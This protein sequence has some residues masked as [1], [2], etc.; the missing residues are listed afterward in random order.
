[1]KEYSKDSGTAEKEGDV[2]WDKMSNLVTQYTD[3]LT[4]LE[5][6]QVSGLVTSDYG[7]H[8]IKCTDVYAAPE[9]VTSLDQIPSE[10]ISTIATSLKSQKQQEAYQQWLEEATAAAD[11][12]INDM[13]QG[14]PYDLDMTKYATATSD[15]G[16]STGELSTDSSTSADNST[17]AGTGDTAAADA[18]S[19]SG[20][21]SETS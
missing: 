12:K 3:A 15:E 4:S 19:T 11:I 2:G 6:D 13:P 14:L 21:P 9:Q 1:M 18:A 16:S 20:Q 10:W 8:I 7:I 5:K 17:S